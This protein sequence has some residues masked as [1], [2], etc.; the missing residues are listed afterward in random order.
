MNEITWK[1]F[2][3]FTDKVAI[4][5]FHELTRDKAPYDDPTYEIWG[6]NEE[7]RFDWLKREDRHFQLHPRW[8][9]SR[10]NNLN[11]P[12]HLLWLKN[13]MG[14]CLLCKGTGYLK[15]GDG[16]DF[17]C[18]FCDK[19]TY[20][21]PVGR[22]KLLIYMQKKHND[23]P[24]SIELP[25]KEVTREFLP[26]KHYYTSSPAYMLSLAMLMGY[27]EIELYGFD[28]GTKTEYHYQRANF[29]Y[30]IGIAH[31]RGIKVTLPGSQIL[32]G[33]LYGYENMKTGYRQQL[34][35]REF[36][37]NKQFNAQRLSC[38]KLEA[39]LELIKTLR[40]NKD[41]DLDKLYKDSRLKLAHT[42]GV[43]N[44]VNGAKT[45]TT[46]LTNLYD[47]YFIAGTEEADGSE[48]S[49]YKENDEHV[50]AV[51]VKEEKNG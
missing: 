5:G 11:D 30:W 13:E 1:D 3:R 18:S 27:K 19:G 44:F 9:F 7:Y 50:S 49:A 31:G 41:T 10:S 37:L 14:Q 25:M 15:G 4:V 21:P 40:D 32:K 42:E 29:E 33:L 34:E 46:N 36:E 17:I 47:S 28:M 39:Q 12:N 6:C 23:I 43:L 38:T 2:P 24:N 51:Y 16:S 45:E 20:S 35:M 26:D 22:G 48:V 8:D